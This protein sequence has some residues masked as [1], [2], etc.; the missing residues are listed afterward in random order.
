MK[1]PSRNRLLCHFNYTGLWLPWK[2]R[3]LRGPAALINILPNQ[4]AV[5]HR[6]WL[7]SSFSASTI[8]HYNIKQNIGT[9][10]K[11][12]IVAQYV[13][14]Y[15]FTSYNTRS[16]IVSLWGFQNDYWWRV[17]I[18]QWAHYYII[19]NVWALPYSWQ[20]LGSGEAGMPRRASL[21]IVISSVSW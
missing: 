3:E 21:A 11:L 8:L 13:E 4:Y 2:R 14:F 6:S 5:L 18:G 1:S 17:V 9:D 15:L 19:L 10:D 12:F 20:N 16:S 7:V